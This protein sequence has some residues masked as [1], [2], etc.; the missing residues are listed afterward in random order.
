MYSGCRNDCAGLFLPFEL[1][2]SVGQLVNEVC[3]MGFALGKVRLGE[4][5]GRML[6]LACDH[7]VKLETSFVTVATSIIV[8]EGVGRQLNPIADLAA[9]ARPLLAEAVANV[10]R[11]S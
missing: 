3:G 9:A 7:R 10:W 4:C 5:F 8:L 11:S 6:T 2:A 1:Q